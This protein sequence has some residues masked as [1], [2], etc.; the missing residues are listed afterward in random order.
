MEAAGDGGGVVRHVSVEEWEARIQPEG[1]VGADPTVALTAACGTLCAIPRAFVDRCGTLVEMLEGGAADVS[2]PPMLEVPDVRDFAVL[3]FLE[4]AD[5][6]AWERARLARICHVASFLGHEAL[7]RKSLAVLASII[8]RTGD[9]SDLVGEIDSLSPL[10][11]RLVVAMLSA[12]D[13]GVPPL[14]TLEEVATAVSA[15]QASAHTLESEPE[16][17]G[18]AVHPLH[19][20]HPPK[21][22]RSLRA[23]AAA[24]GPAAVAATISKLELDQLD[25]DTM[26]ALFSCMDLSSCVRLIQCSF[27]AVSMVF[28]DSDSWK[29]AFRAWS[30][31]LQDPLTS[32][33]TLPQP[34]MVDAA[35]LEAIQVQPDGADSAGWIDRVARLVRLVRDMHGFALI[36]RTQQETPRDPLEKIAWVAARA[37]QLGGPDPHDLLAA[38]LLVP[39]MRAVVYS[40]CTEKRLPDGAWA[41]AVEAFSR[42]VDHSTAV[43][44]SVAQAELSASSD[45][46]LLKAGGE[47]QRRLDDAWVRCTGAHTLQRAIFAALNEHLRRAH[48]PTLLERCERSVSAASVWA[49]WQERGWV[50]PTMQPTEELED[51]VDHVKLLAT[52]GEIFTVSIGVAQTFNAVKETLQAWQITGHV[53]RTAIPVGELESPVLAKAIEFATYHHMAESIAEDAVAEWVKQFIDVDQGTLFHLILAAN[54]L[55]H[56]V[57]LDTG[58]KAVADMIKGKTPEE[59]RVRPL[60]L[61][62]LHSD[63]G[64][65]SAYALWKL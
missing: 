10:V 33:A 64:L 56:K 6:A 37:E 62:S 4:H 42:V 7:L 40:A 31:V 23:V 2:G 41:Q 52:D 11:D 20:G 24:V 63:S 32:D 8:T 30:A 16:S 27:S 54:L 13:P 21:R 15:W 29:F 5:D 3:L 50:Q 12:T 28:T 51:A 17:E 22:R 36:G 18:G 44:A 1:A 55:G 34:S 26:L 49:Q 43:S 38:R 57:L 47:Q 59:I 48:E 19:E 9:L 45:G 53:P 39:H 58:C 25:P 35:T 61:S 14:S 60:Q 46:G 65:F